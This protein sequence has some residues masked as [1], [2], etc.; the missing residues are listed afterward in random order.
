[1][2]LQLAPG[3][4]IRLYLRMLTMSAFDRQDEH[5]QFDVY[6]GLWRRSFEWW[7]SRGYPCHVVVFGKD[8]ILHGEFKSKRAAR[9][10]A[11]DLIFKCCRAGLAWPEQPRASKVT[12]T[13]QTLG[14]PESGMPL[15][16]GNMADV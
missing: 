9:G 8:E 14:Q 5:W 3:Q 1:V 13:G 11:Q 10:F 2:T 6:S 12:I 16:Q 4:E 15:G 7:I